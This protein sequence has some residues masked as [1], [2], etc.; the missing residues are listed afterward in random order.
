MRI[1]PLVFVCQREILCTIPRVKCKQTVISELVS[2][3]LESSHHFVIFVRQNMTVPHILS[4]FGKFGLDYGNLARPGRHDI[5]ELCLLGH[6]VIAHLEFFGLVRQGSILGEMS[7][8]ALANGA[9]VSR[10][11]LFGETNAIHGPSIRCTQGGCLLDNGCLPGSGGLGIKNELVTAN[12]AKI[13]Q[14]QMNGMLSFKN[15]QKRGMKSK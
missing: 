13:H 10:N 4:W 8:I 9:V 7:T 1:A 12:D 3:Y 5:L 6:K 14:V 15:H 2:G 11:V